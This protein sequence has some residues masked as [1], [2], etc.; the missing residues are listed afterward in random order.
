MIVADKDA[1]SLYR[2]SLSPETRELITFEMDV[3]KQ[4]DW[5][6][7]KSKVEEEF[8]GMHYLSHFPYLL[9]IWL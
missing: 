5:G 6:R 1:S 3:G 2:L 8:D 9:V 7:L 4:E